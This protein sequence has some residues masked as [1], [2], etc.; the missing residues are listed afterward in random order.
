MFIFYIFV[1]FQ[2]GISNKLILTFLPT[3]S[4]MIL[5]L[6]HRLYYGEFLQ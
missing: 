5:I 3:F 1:L 6:L 4:I 2:Y